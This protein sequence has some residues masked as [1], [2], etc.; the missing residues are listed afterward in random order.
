MQEFHITVS[1]DE[2]LQG[3]RGSSLILILCR[4]ASILALVPAN[5]SRE[6]KQ[7]KRFWR[8]GRSRV[9][10]RHARRA[11]HNVLH[12]V[13]IADPQVSKV[14]II[15]I[16]DSRNL[17]LDLKERDCDAKVSTEKAGF[18]AKKFT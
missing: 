8:L 10:V 3:T 14:R 1:A 13:G 16:L 17:K 18:L 2:C 7:P 9:C 6:S 12:T 4:E 5:T 15:T 11:E